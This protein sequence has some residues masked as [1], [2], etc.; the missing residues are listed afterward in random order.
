MEERTVGYK[1]GLTGVEEGLDAFDDFKTDSRVGGER[2][3]E[4]SLGPGWTT[5]R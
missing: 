2:G 4:D 3:D 1:V 5:K